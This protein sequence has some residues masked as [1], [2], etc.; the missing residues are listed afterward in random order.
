VTERGGFL[1]EL[2]VRDG[3]SVRVGDVLAV[4]SNPELEIKLRVNEADRALRL[5]QKTALLA[6]LTEAGRGGGETAADLQEAEFVLKTL[7]RE[8]ATLREQYERLTLRAPGDGV[9]LGLCS[10]EDRGKWFDAGAELCR[11]GGPQ[12]L[13]AVLLVPAADHELIGPGKRAW[14]RVHGG[15]SAQWSGVVADVAQV[16]ATTVPPQLAGQAGGEV[17]TQHDPVSKTDAPYHPHYLCAVR[18]MAADAVLQSGVLGRVRIEAGW[19]TPWWRLRR[20]LASAFGM[21]V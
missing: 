15:G 18:L 21:S 12:A 8:R 6:Q 20:Y 7:L 3:Q 11:V 14:L 19:Q 4:L 5:R 9:V 2:F 13:R 10:L 17:A 16:E 1:Q